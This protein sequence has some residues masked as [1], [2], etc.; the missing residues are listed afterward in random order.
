M[1]DGGTRPCT[2]TRLDVTQIQNDHLLDSLSSWLSG[3]F[4][5]KSR[6]L[7]YLSSLGF[8]QKFMSLIFFS[9][10]P[11]CY[12]IISPSLARISTVSIIS[13]SQLSVSSSWRRQIVRSSQVP[14]PYGLLCG[15][16]PYQDL[17]ADHYDK[18]NTKA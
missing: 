8:C 16:V 5:P 13:S 7:S 4:L 11:C 15:L 2:S 18:P 1:V 12:L 17:D 9:A 10:L 6:F 14:S 3:K